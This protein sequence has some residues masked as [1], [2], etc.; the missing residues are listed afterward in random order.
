M[1]THSRLCLLVVLA[2]LAPAGAQVQQ[3]S[4]PAGSDAD[5]ALQAIANEQD[6]QK[7]MTQ[8]ADFVKQYASEPPAVAYAYSQME[9]MA[10]SAGNLPQALAYGD[11][12]LAVLPGSMD[13]LVAQINVTQQMKDTA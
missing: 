2:L 4:I 11:Q 1:K 10:Q 5:K 3:M 13:V 12:A 6:A 8:Y 9:Q 7:R